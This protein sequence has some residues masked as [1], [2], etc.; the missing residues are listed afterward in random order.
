L[1]VLITLPLIERTFGGPAEK[2]RHLRSG[3]IRMGHDVVAVGCGSADWAKGL[4]AIGRYHA[5][6]IPLEIKPILL[7]V[8]KADVVHIIGFRDPVGTIAALAAKSARVPYVLEPVGMY[9]RKLRSFHLKKAF[10]WTLGATVRR[11]A[12]RII[13]TSRSEASE[14][15]A[16][17]FDSAGLVLR[18]NGVATDDLLPLPE[19][20]ALRKELGISPE[21]PLVVALGRIARIKGLDLLMR[22][23]AQIP[24]ASAVI[25]GPDARDGTLR[26]LIE[27]QHELQLED[28]CLIIPTGFWGRR[29][30]QLFSDA[31][32]LCQPSQSESFGNSAAEA[33]AVGLPVVVTDSCGVADWLGGRAFQAVPYGDVMALRLA[34]EEL[35]QPDMRTAAVQAADSVRKLLDWDAVA[36]RQSEVYEELMDAGTE[37]R[38]RSE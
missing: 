9:G 24:G 38:H 13:V 22:V 6:P 5:T 7:G 10:D 37:A 33:A 26:R 15:K 36:L 2:A 29:K 25:A 11:G 8:R 21:A 27:V 18:P 17:W 32:V 19:R 30:A 3:L 34:I 20:G 1:R 23:V 4:R 16:F 12:A 28:R 35:V 14:L 31:D